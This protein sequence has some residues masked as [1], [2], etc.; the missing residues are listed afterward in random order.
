MKTIIIP[1]MAFIALTLASCNAKQSASNSEATDSTTVSTVDE[2]S[3][4]AETQITTEADEVISQ[5]SEQL[6]KNDKAAFSELSKKAQA[7]IEKYIAAGD[8]ES[9]QIYSA[10]LKKFMDENIDKVRAVATADD[11]I[12]T[13]IST[14]ANT[15]AK[16]IADGITNAAKADAEGIANEVK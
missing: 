6:S 14:V 7:Q 11:A 16:E 3:T 8:T 2:I 13:L 15:S 5:M 4:E 10:Q 1:A 9:A 12:S